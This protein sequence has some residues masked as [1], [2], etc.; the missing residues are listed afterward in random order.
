MEA[1][2]DPDRTGSV[3]HWEVAGGADCGLMKKEKIKINN[4]CNSSIFRGCI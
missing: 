4:Y 3:K 2:S 1:V